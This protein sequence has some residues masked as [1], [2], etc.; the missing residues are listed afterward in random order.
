LALKISYLGNKKWGDTNSKVIFRLTE[1][2]M[3]SRISEASSK[4]ISTDGILIS[5]PMSKKNKL[6][7]G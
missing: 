7:K 6:G 5:E 2:S 3:N 1:V 4:L